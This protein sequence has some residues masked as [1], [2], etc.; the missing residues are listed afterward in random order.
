MKIK[1]IKA[2]FFK[3][4]SISTLIMRTLILFLSLALFSFAPSEL[5]SQNVKIVIKK[6]QKATVDQIFEL[7]KRQTQYRF[8]YRSDMFDDLP[9]IELEK[10]TIS[11]STLLEKSLSKGNFKYEVASNNTIIIKEIPV[12]KSQKTEAVESIEIKGKVTDTNGQPIPGIT[13][14]V[15][16]YKPSG[17]AN[18]KNF[19][20]RGTTTDFDG[21]FSI[22]AEVGYYLVA[23][24]IGFQFYTEEITKSKTTYSI[25]LKEEVSALEEVMVVGYGTTKKKDLTGS[26]SSITSEDIQQIKTQT[27]DNAL[28]GK[29]PGVNV[30][31]RGGAPGAG[32]SVNIRGLTQIRGDNQPLYVID[33][34]PISITPN[35]ESLGLI[36]YGS[37]ENPLLAINPDDVER[38]DVLKDAS[39]A[40]IYGSRAASGVIIVTT[41][42]GKRNQ[43]PRFSFNASSTFQNPVKMYDYLSADQ[44]I[45]FS[46]EKAQQTLNQYPEMY[47]SYFPQEFAIVNNPD[48]YFGKA[49]TN[50]QD[51][52]TNKNA[53]WTQYSFNVNGGS[54]R[55]NYMMSAGISDQQGVMIENDFKRYTFSTNLDANITN[56]FKV[57]GSVNYNYS[58][59]KIKGFNSLALG[60]FRPDLPAF[61]EDGSYSTFVGNYGEQY[62]ALGD[63]MQTRSKALSKNLLGS[64]YAEVQIISGLKF[65]SQLNASV[66]SDETNGFSTSKSTNAL[67]Y[68]LYYDRPG[69]R[70]DV[71]HNEGWTTAF[72]NTL[73]YNK[74][75]SENHRIDAVAGVSWNRTRYDANAQHYRGFPDDDTLINIGSSNFTD[76]VESESIEQGLNSIFG[77]V[78]Y[79]YKSKYLATFTA[80]RDGSTKF[81]PDNRYGFFPS[82]ALAWNVHNE[83]FMKEVSFVNQLKLRASIGRTGSDNLPSFTYLAYYQSLENGDSFYD[84]KNG[85]AVTGV[86]NSKIKWE[87]TNQLDLGIDF[88]MF[89]NRLTGEL[90]YFEKN[91]SG[92]ILFTPLPYETGSISWN[93]NVADVSNKGWEFLIGVDIFRT[94]NFRWNSSFNISTIKNNVDNIYGASA[95]SQTVIEG[96][97]LGVITG[98]DVIK[99]AQTQAEIDA[100]NASAGGVYQST[101]TQPGDYIFK[102]INGDGKIT[103][104]DRGP[105]G[106]IN[107]DY[108]GGWNN[109]VTY[110]NWDFTMNWNF[111]QGAQRQYEKISNLYYTDAITN[112]TPEVFD[113]WTPENPNAS[114]A[115]YASPTHGYTAT[116]RSV[117]D[118]SYIKLRSASIGY[119]LPSSLFKN[120]GLS[121][122]RLSLSGNNLITITDYPG[123][124]PEDVIST[125]FANRTTGFTRDGGNSY[126]NVRTFT[127][128]LNVTF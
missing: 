9:K 32:S 43:A 120:T 98:Y 73:S 79:S 121:K 125:S 78:N 59:N 25:I 55:V 35:S 71:Q 2:V 11:V 62:T 29:I 91:T 10:G 100:L 60:S 90:V 123:L 31:S 52:I 24:G 54:E 51:L 28:I 92:I 94:K 75:I 47:W 108:F 111:S 27:I 40:A 96:Q 107:P 87:E 19:V 119:N 46:T 99:I 82:G 115:R 7:I 72:E 76:S 84:G 44:Y 16:S 21:T 33:G 93:T 14:Y 41:K 15:S 30:S 3:R 38:I 74:T 88:S 109:T 6:D 101:L 22:T 70:L 61:N 4:K 128:S 12:Q 102:D 103:T 49:N 42:R 97:P 89:N 53:L 13:V 112:P 81:G 68:G 50:W 124:D 105:I 122:V 23:S 17:N 117:V 116:S 20:I 45:K 118:A 83:D 26:V 80:R 63:G 127:F 1:F 57:G 36:N 69:A 8:V 66:N 106:D 34:T 77:R 85:I 18:T 86:P 110:K 104:L 37:R 56:S 67:F 65:K 95:G 114:Y 39:A 64:I 5:L 113:T 58:I 48:T 126:P